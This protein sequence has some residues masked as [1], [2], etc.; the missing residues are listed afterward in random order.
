MQAAMLQAASQ[1]M[2][3]CGKLAT[4]VT[5]RATTAWRNGLVGNT[6]RTGIRA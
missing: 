6:P 1:L 5:G 4:S 2:I 3:Q